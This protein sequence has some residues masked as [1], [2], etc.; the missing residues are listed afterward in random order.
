MGDPRLTG[1]RRHVTGSR[2]H[3]FDVIPGREVRHRDVSTLEFLP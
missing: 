1:G 2:Q 3:A